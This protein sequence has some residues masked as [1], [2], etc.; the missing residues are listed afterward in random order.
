MARAHL[1][2]GLVE[3]AFAA[4]AFF[5]EKIK[6]RL[7]FKVK[8]AEFQKGLP[9][10]GKLKIKLHVLGRDAD[11]GMTVIGGWAEARVSRKGGKYRMEK[12]RLTELQP[13]DRYTADFFMQN[14]ACAALLEQ[15]G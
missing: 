4:L 12:L 10:W 9:A 3:T 8:G 14:R 11:G 13:T 6:L 15:L 2:Y 1:V 7:L 5:L